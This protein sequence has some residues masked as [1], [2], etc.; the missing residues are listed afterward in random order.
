MSDTRT[1]PPGDSTPLCQAFFQG[2]GRSIPWPSRA[3]PVV[4]AALCAMTDQAAAAWPEVSLDAARFV[5]HVGERLTTSEA[6]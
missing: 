5:R 3:L 1:D 6:P 4:E 2:A